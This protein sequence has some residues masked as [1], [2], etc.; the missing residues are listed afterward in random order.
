MDRKTVVALSTLTLLIACNGPSPPPLQLARD[1]TLRLPIYSTP[2]PGSPSLDPASLSATMETAIGDNIFDGLYRFNEQMQEQPDIAKGM[3][4][5]SADGLTYIFHLRHNVHFW[6]GDPVT[7]A[8]FIYSW[9]RAAAINGDWST[10]F[11][12]VAGYA[13]VVAAGRVTNETRLDVTAPDDYT[14]VAR[15]SAASGYWLAELV[16]PAAWVVDQNA[17]ALLKLYPLPTNTSL[18]SNYA[19]S[20][21]LNERRNAFD[22]RL[23]FNFS[24]KNQVFA[25]FSLVDD[26]QFIPG[27]FGG[28]ADGGAFQEGTQTA[29]VVGNPGDEI[30]TDKYG[31]VKVQFPWDRKGQKDANSSC[32][33][34]AP[35]AY[36][37]FSTPW[38]SRLWRSCGSRRPNGAGAGG[39]PRM[40]LERRDARSH[41]YQTL[42]ARALNLP[43]RTIEVERTEIDIRVSRQRRKSDHGINEPVGSIAFLLCFLPRSADKRHDSSQRF[44]RAVGTAEPGIFIPHTERRAEH[45]VPGRRNVENDLCPFDRECTS[46]VRCAGLNDDGPALR[47]RWNIERAARF[48]IGLIAQSSG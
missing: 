28:V 8:D 16:L 33:R 11:Q 46:S 6:N 38:I 40:A 13:A 47:A 20:P 12:P 48:E 24:D 4:S 2:S 43:D 39:R 10:I 41:R 45:V 18:L 23:D 34:S 21:T 19:N 29:I 32:S 1:Q 9:N 31:R 25:R 7:A 17:I 26:P 36:A 5:V 42:R 14:L 22:T 35:R 3:P 30:F 37:L 27:I 44:A 15:L